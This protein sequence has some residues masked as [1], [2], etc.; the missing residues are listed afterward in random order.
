MDSTGERA[1]D[2]VAEANAGGGGIPRPDEPEAA[3]GDPAVVAGAKDGTA[4]EDCAAGENDQAEGD[5]AAYELKD[6]R[7]VRLK[8]DDLNPHLVCR[9]CSGYFRGAHTITECLHTFCKSC[10]LKEF[11]KGLRSCPH[12]KVPVF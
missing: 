11:D 7:L 3:R 10:L 8:L 6:T 9:I 4:A 1:S 12:C 5:D 2:D